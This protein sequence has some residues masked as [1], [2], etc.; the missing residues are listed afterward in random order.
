MVGRLAAWL[1]LLVAAV[2]VWDVVMRRLFVQ[3]S[4]LLQELEWHLHAL[5]I[6]SCLAWA[7]G[8]DEHI[9]IDLFH[10]HMSMRRRN[11][12]ELWGCLLLLLPWSMW[13]SV[14]GWRFVEASFALGESSQAPGG[15]GMRWLIKAVLPLGMGLLSLQGW[16]KVL[17]LLVLPTETLRA[18]SEPRPPAARAAAP[19]SS[20]V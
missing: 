13:T 12:V 8:R 15:L 9:R 16:A 17:K 18:E 3:G 14:L 1:F 10:S 11:Q 6:M 7:Y 2:I 4:V 19:P 20:F 5:G